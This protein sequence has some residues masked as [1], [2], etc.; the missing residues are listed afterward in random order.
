MCPS[1][2]SAR[3]RTGTCR[4]SCGNPGGSGGLVERHRPLIG[5]HVHAL[6]NATGGAGRS[7]AGSGSGLPGA[8]RR[9]LVEYIPK[10]GELLVELCGGLVGRLEGA[11]LRAA[12]DRVG[13][14]LLFRPFSRPQPGVL[15]GLPA[16][17]GADGADGLLG[18]VEQ[19]LGFLG[20]DREA[21]NVWVHAVGGRVDNDPV[22]RLRSQWAGLGTLCRI[23]QPDQLRRW[24]SRP[25]IASHP[26]HKLFIIDVRF[27]RPP[28]HAGRYPDRLAAKEF[29]PAFDFLRIDTS[30]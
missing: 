30:A 18:L 21:P 6:V 2:S 27:S 24:R 7:T 13:H 8:I 11:G 22:G 14:A 9:G 3:G 16:A 1:R 15:S 12:V 19:E 4:E 28:A 20:V 23:R 25:P 29:I 26:A 17:L 5:H 10:P